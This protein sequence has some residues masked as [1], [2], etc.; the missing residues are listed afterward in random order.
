M[1]STERLSRPING[2]RHKI[3]RVGTVHVRE[4]FERKISYE[5]ASWYTLVEVPPGKY[6]VELIEEFGRITWAMIRYEGEITK[7]HFVNRVFWASSVHEPTENIGKIRGCSAQ[8]Y[9]YEVAEMF[10]TNPDFEICEDWEA[11]QS[12]TF[13]SYDGTEKPMYAIRRREV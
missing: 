9:A 7:E 2:R 13:T 6:S 8:T 4:T 5:T 3:I 11:Y 1:Y 12:G 10:A